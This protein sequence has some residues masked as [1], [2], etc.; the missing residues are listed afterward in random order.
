[1]TGLLL[2]TLL[3]LSPGIVLADN[4][5]ARNVALSDA[6]L[7]LQFVADDGPRPS[8]D[9]MTREQLAAELRR[10]DDTKPSI[11]GPIVLLSIGAGLSIPG[12]YFLISGLSTA[13]FNSGT[14]TQAAG[15]ILAGFGGVLLTAGLIL[16]I[17]GAI[18]LPMRLSKRTAHAEETEQIRRKMDTMDQGAPPPPPGPEEMVPPPPPPP[19][20]QAN[21]VVPGAMRTVMT[22]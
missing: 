12:A 22:F 9:T 16:V 4:V 10:L 5:E 15:Y 20:P 8:L 1:M 17:V 19:P 11:G 3:N 2:A 18:L 13:A 21:F 14:F 6:R 7:R